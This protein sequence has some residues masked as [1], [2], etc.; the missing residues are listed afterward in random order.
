AKYA[1]EQGL[2]LYIVNIEPE[3]AEEKYAIFRHQ[4][5]KLAEITGGKFFYM[6]G[7]NNLAQ[8]YSEIDKLEKS[9]IPWNIEQELNKKYLPDRYKRVSLYPWLIAIGLALL[10]CSALLRTTRLRGVP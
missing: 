10:A 8:V 7:S 5:E 4:M 1:Q 3:F 9:K 2:R 6:T